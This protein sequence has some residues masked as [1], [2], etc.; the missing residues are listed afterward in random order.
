MQNGIGNKT[1][2]LTDVDGSGELLT[3]LIKYP[4]ETR[5]DNKIKVAATASW[6][7]GW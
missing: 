6:R 1:K 7:H 4:A 2:N 3:R 5:S